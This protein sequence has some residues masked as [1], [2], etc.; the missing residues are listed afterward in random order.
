MSSDDR[1]LTSWKDIA[2][3]LGVHVRTVQKWERERGLPIRRAPGLRGRVS[4]DVAAL[5]EWKQMLPQ[6]PTSGDCY[7]WPLGR[8]I[9]AEVRFTGSGPNAEAIELL[10]KYLSLLKTAF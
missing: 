4:A 9:V 1:Q 2:H 6:A 10:R 8:G 7:R 3:H 5:D